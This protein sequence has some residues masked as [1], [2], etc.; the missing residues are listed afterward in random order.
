MAT[1]EQLQEA[2]HRIQAQEARIAALEMQVQVE[3]TRTQHVNER[4]LSRL[5]DL[6]TEIDLHPGSMS[7][8]SVLMRRTRSTGSMISLESS[9]HA[10]S[11]LQPT[12]LTES[13]GTQAKEMA[14][15]RG[16][17]CTASTT[18][19][20]PCDAWRSFSKFRT[21]R[22]ASELR[23]CAGGLGLKETSIRDVH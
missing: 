4:L 19:R 21:H 6:R 22:D 10:M 1:E 15:K 14:W 11:P 2:L 18:P 23:I 13:S 5:A 8:W 7:L 17:D 16:D 3:K 9:T 20:R 12:H